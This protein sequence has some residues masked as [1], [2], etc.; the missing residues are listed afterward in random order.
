[1]AAVNPY[2]DGSL[3]L[4]SGL[5]VGQLAKVKLDSEV[6]HANNCSLVPNMSPANDP[7]I[8]LDNLFH[9]AGSQADGAETPED[10]EY[11]NNKGKCQMTLGIYMAETTAA[12]ITAFLMRIAQGL[13]VTAGSN[14]EFWVTAVES[15]LAD[16][17]IFTSPSLIA[18]LPTINSQL[19]QARHVPMFTRTLAAQMQFCWLVLIR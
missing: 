19:H 15:K 16:L 5:F 8:C 2:H 9:V 18:S 12:D 10:Q 4:Q 11:G 7:T 13:K 14:V 17:G 3:H 6:L 1:L